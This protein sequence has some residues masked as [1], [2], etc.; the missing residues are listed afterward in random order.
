MMFVE[1]KPREG[2]YSEELMQ[3]ISGAWKDL[4]F[5]GGI[6]ANFYN[7]EADK[8]LVSMQ[9][10]WDGIPLRD[11]L[12][13]QKEVLKVTWDNHD[14]TLEERE[15]QSS[16]TAKGRRR[17]KSKRQGRRAKKGKKKTKPREL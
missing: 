1:L 8:I 16:P 12:L 15:K 17:P 10:G 13:D 9:K 6:Q 7:I 5:T 3:N 11:F 14:Y 2:G 4:L